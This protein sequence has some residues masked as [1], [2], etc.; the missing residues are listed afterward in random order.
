M[1]IINVWLPSTVGNL[2]GITR[3]RDYTNFNKNKF[4]NFGNNNPYENAWEVNH[5]VSNLGSLA[6]SVGHVSLHVRNKEHDLYMSLYPNYEGKD[7]NIALQPFT[8]F[9]SKFI[10]NYDIDKKEIESD[11]DYNIVLK[12][13]DE[14][15]IVSRLNYFNKKYNYYNL[16]SSNCSHLAMEALHIGSNNKK[17]SLRENVK[18]IWNLLSNVTNTLNYFNNITDEKKRYLRQNIPAFQPVKAS[19]SLMELCGGTTPYTV[20][21]YANFLKESI[22]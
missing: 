9:R 6:R 11:P 1:V 12:N 21:N 5:T 17:Y 3:T 22:G 2:S 13:L 18:N 19:A 4:N 16:Y 10:K 8:K 14:K 20:I 15:R 7:I